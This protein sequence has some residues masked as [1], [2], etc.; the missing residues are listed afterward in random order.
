MPTMIAT[1]MNSL[2]R[3]SRLEEHLENLALSRQPVVID[4]DALVHSPFKFNSD[5]PEFVPNISQDATCKF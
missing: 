4:L 5:A 3:V 2:K 1:T